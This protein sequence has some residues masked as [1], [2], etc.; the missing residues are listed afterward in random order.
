ME[1]GF[2]NAV[3]DGLSDVKFWLAMLFDSASMTFPLIA[4]GIFTNLPFQLVQILGTLPFLFM[5][6]FS[7]TFSPGSGVPGLKA[8]RYLFSRFYFWCMIPEVEDLMEGCPSTETANIWYMIL[9]S[10]VGVFVFVVLQIIFKIKNRV[11]KNKSNVKLASLM[12]DDE[13]HELQIELYGAKTLRRFQNMN[14]TE[15][16]TGKDSIL[17][18]VHVKTT[19]DESIIDSTI[20]LSISDK[21]KMDMD[22]QAEIEFDRTSVSKKAFR[23]TGV[24]SLFLSHGQGRCLIFPLSKDSLCFNY[25]TNILIQYL[26]K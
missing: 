1:F 23:I 5:I 9:S 2:V 3:I 21:V 16:S 13:F 19:T 12:N 25:A 18:S 6:F 17:D 14:S 22:E 8:L 4:L 7:T 20:H 10:L 15:H 11:V 24:F 26:L